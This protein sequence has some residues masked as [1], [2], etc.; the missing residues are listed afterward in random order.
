ML[1]D[2]RLAFSENK[3]Q[4]LEISI[5]TIEQNVASCNR[6]CEDKVTKPESHEKEGNFT[7]FRINKKTII[8]PYQ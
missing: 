5:K 1:V 6:I 8:F 2:R 3:T 4:T 7:A